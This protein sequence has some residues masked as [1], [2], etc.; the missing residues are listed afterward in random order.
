MGAPGVAQRVCR[1]DRLFLGP[2]GPQVGYLDRRARPF[3]RGLP[4]V[5]RYRPDGAVG[6]H[7]FSHEASRT[8]SAWRAPGVT[9]RD[10]CRAAR[11]PGRPAVVP[12]WRIPC[13]IEPWKALADQA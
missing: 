9:P 11:P 4:P 10:G 13:R 2:I 12:R 8:R 5:A 7:R 3:P 6:G 1:L